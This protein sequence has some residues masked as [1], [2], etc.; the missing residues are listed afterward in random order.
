MKQRLH[1][2]N[3]VLRFFLPSVIVFPLSVLAQKENNIWYFGFGAGIDFNSGSPVTLT[4]GA[5]N[6]TEGCASISDT[7]GNLLFYTDGVTVYNKV[8]NVM[9]NGMG[10]LGGNSSS[11]S[12]IIVPLP[13]SSTVYYIF[14]TPN[15]GLLDGLNYSVVDMSLQGGLGEVTILNSLLH[16]PIGEKVCATRH[17]NGIDYWIV[18]HEYASDAFYSFEL[19]SSGVNPVPVICNVGLIHNG[20]HGYLK[21]TPDGTTIGLAIGEI[22]EI[23][24]FDFD[25]TTGVISNPITFPATYSYPYGVEFS[26]DN[27]KFYV[28]LSGVAGTAGIYQFDL[29]AG[30]PAAIIASGLLVGSSTNQ[31]MGP[32]QLGPDGKIYCARYLTPYIGVIDNPNAMGLACS[33][34]DTAIFLNSGTSMFGLPNQIPR[35]DFIPAA[36]FSADNHICPGTCTDF[37]NLS[38]N[39]TSYIWTF[40]GANPGVST[41]ANPMQICY[42]IPG[43][44][45]VTLI[46]SNSNGSDTLTLLNFMTVYPQPSPQGIMQSGD[47]LFANQ[48]AISY[49]WFHDGNL[50]TGAT[51]YFYIA[52]QS[53]NFNVVATDANGCEVEAAIFDII[54]NATPLSER[55]GSGV[56]LSPN[57][58]NDDLTIQFNNLS[59]EDIGIEIY[60]AAGEKV[61][62]GTT[63]YSLNS[64][65][66]VDVRNFATGLYCLKAIQGSENSA[67]IF[68]KQ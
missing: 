52:G 28:A 5:L 26:P 60:N 35:F 31:Y 25:R 50:I 45:S 46:A 19:T 63:K 22:D 58:V 68:I 38:Q 34:N 48:G 1:F 30:S 59:V 14:T 3:V 2:F 9:T 16:A 8:H 23:E 37:T 4:N 20:Y 7:S 29:H 43:Q 13:G 17:S 47:T 65:L 18:A 67:T 24:L 27:S 51:D 21:F 54:A 66:K 56:R 39:A 12:A 64:T 32:L 42:N 40:P 10:L 41:D 53:G 33:Y 62:S 36:I 57:P 49:Q 55:D 6:T 44:Y 11:E 15:Q 61:Y